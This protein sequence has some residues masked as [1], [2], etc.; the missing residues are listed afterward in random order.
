MDEH[1]E[2]EH[3]VPAERRPGR[4]PRLLRLLLAGAV[5]VAGAACEGG[6]AGRPRVATTTPAGPMVERYLTDALDLIQRHAFYA[7]R[8]DWPAARAEARRRAAGATTTAGTYDAIRWVLSKLGDRHSLLLTPE[9]AGE[10]KAGGF[11]PS[12]GMLALFPERVVV[13]VEPGGAAE[14][15]GVRVGDVVLAVDGRSARGEE[16]LDLPAPETGGGPARMRLDLRR[17]DGTVHVTVEAADLPAVRPPTARR[18]SARVNLLELFAVVGTRGD[19]DGSRYVGPAY[20]AI[21]GVSTAAT[22]GWVVDLRRD[23]GGSIPPMLQAVGPILGDG[24]AVGY[25]DRD[26]AT[27][28]FSIE[29]GTLAGMGPA[30]VSAGRPPR[31][32]RPRPPVAVLTSRL[33]GS[34]GEGVVMAFR[35]RPDTRSFGEF[36]AGV[37]TSNAAYP[38]PDRAELHL[39][40]GIGVDRTGATYQTRIRPDRPVASDWTRYGTRADP[41]VA[42]ASRWLEARC[43]RG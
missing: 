36:T 17:G 28:W 16:V 3:S 40:E 24:R 26:G 11:G 23:T 22:C 15:A 42:A 39:T 30:A 7:G 10:L 5:V 1:R 43:A 41:V 34:S 27:Q 6:R 8:V 2:K 12:F 21:R 25:R 37:P 38:L 4:S 31:L 13:D 19:P 35:G 14:R 20:D 18:P 9:R 32:R 33:T 29:D